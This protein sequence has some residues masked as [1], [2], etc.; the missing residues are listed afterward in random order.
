MNVTISKETALKNYFGY[1]EFRMGQ[2]EI[3]DSIVSGRDTLVV[4]PTGG[5]KSLCFQLPSLMLIGTAIVISPLIALMKDQVDSL[6]RLNISATFINSTLSFSEIS[7]RINN[8]IQGYYKLIYIAPERL[9]SRSFCDM[10]KDINISFL[11]VDEAH[12]ISE[13]GHDFRPSY[14]TIP[15]AF[16]DFGNLPK[17]ALTATATP[18]VQSDISKFL[19]MSRPEL[20]VRGFDRPNLYYSSIQVKN[21]SEWMINR[22]KKVNSGSVIIYCGS[23]KRTDAFASSLRSSGLTVESYHAGLMP[24]ERKAVQDRFIHGRSNIIVATNAF[25]MGI[26]KADVREVIH[27]DLTSTLEA[28]YQEAGRAGR[29]GLDANCTLLYQKSDRRLQ[30]F[31]INTTYP[32]INKLKSI[33][34]FL[35]DITQTPLNRKAVSSISLSE[36][37]IGNMMGLPRSIIDSALNFFERIGIISR[38]NVQN[39]GMVRIAASREFIMDYYDQAGDENRN[40]LEA[41]LRSVSKSAFSGPEQINLSK[42]SRDFGIPYERIQKT[43]ASL[44]FIGI[45]KYKPDSIQGGI[46]INNERRPFESLGAK[47]EEFSVRKEFAYMKLQTMINYA[48]TKGC[49]RSFILNYFNE[50]K[51]DF[52]CGNCGSCSNPI[53]ISEKL[54]NKDVFVTRKL[55]DAIKQFNGKFGKM[56]FIDFVKGAGNEK[57][58]KYGLE[59]TDGF[60]SCKEFSKNEIRDI[61][62][63]L[64]AE[65]QVLISSDKYP[66]LHLNNPQQND[67]NQIKVQISNYFDK[68]LFA[69]LIEYRNN[70]GIRENLPP[71]SIIS[72]EALKLLSAYNNQA[73]LDDALIPNRSKYFHVFQNIANEYFAGIQNNKS[74]KF[75][76]NKDAE[77][78]GELINLGSSISEIAKMMNLSEG[79]VAALAVNAVDSGFVIKIEMLSNNHKYYEIQRLVRS[80][81]N[82]LLKDVRARLKETVDFP[83]LRILIA[84]ARKEAAQYLEGKSK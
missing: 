66:V 68:R 78:V 74:E 8:A 9:A 15:D 69:K 14:L 21:K 53:I 61:L 37:E 83:V 35:F 42:I 2:A 64:I 26:N 28:Y 56:F 70:L 6:S 27:C 22:L 13:W 43:I 82:I 40:I 67:K 50:Q 38:E 11:A 48:E 12:C 17:L 44:E 24:N 45:L 58:M 4:M 79:E 77:R 16:P 63:D 41:I 31:F 29:D 1:D 3:I 59:M 51:S 36:I 30:E 65:G 75:E 71:L 54:S 7:E 46:V 49:K 18:E 10:L 76:I 60:G 25:G 19:K 20:F 84:I 34:D 23:R 57:I 55:I 73:L 52:R 47:V 80:N 39:S 33:Y 62:E 32:E 5:G 81:R 72:D